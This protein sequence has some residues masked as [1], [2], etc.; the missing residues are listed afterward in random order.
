MSILNYF[1]ELY[2]NTN[3]YFEFLKDILSNREISIIFW[4]LVFSG[5]VLFSSNMQEVRRSL[6][7]VLK[8][9]FHIKILLVLFF[10]S[11]YMCLSVY[12]LYLINLWDSSQ[13]K[14]TVIWYFSIGIFSLFKII[15]EKKT[16][17]FFKNLLMDFL[18]ISALIEF[19]INF[20]SLNLVSEIIVVPIFVLLGGLQ[21]FSQSKDEYKQVAKVINGILIVSGLLLFVHAINNISSDYKGFFKKETFQDF[22]TPLLLTIEY[23]PFLYIMSIYVAYEQSFLRLKHFIKNPEILKYSKMYAIFKFHI[24]TTLLDRWYSLLSI[25]QIENKSDVKNSISEIYNIVRIEK[26]PPVIEKSEGWSP[27]IAK[28]F[29]LTEGIKPGYYSPIGNN[30]WFACST[31]IKLEKGFDANDIAYY[32]SGNKHAANSLKIVLNVNSRA[33]QKMAK[34]KLLSAAG[35]LFYK[36]IGSDLPTSII[37]AILHGTNYQSNIGLFSVKLEKFDWLAKRGS[38]DLKF[39]IFKK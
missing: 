12:G 37:K 30:E 24:R 29:L 14:N 39:H 4:F 19:L 8:G 31:Y 38:Y 9:F 36:S 22:Y 28:D 2:F 7:L 25:Y 16:G 21:A 17:N 35:L 3:C 34:Q 10:L 32:I 5:Y 11:T 26:N 6:I 23:I 15:S 18:K 33:S 20:Y 1:S 27:Y 13:I